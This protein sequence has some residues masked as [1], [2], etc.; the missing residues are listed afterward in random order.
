MP[1]HLQKPR[2][3]L[4]ATIAPQSPISVR[5]ALTASHRSPMTVATTTP[6]SEV[7]EVSDFPSC[8][9]SRMRAFL[10]GDEIG[11]KGKRAKY[12]IR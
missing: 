5:F 6:I 12:G 2:L 11:Y 10:I 7:S 3:A 9:I 8:S 4:N 1:Q